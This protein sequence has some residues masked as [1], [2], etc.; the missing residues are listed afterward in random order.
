MVCGILYKIVIKMEQPQD[1][2]YWQERYKRYKK[3]IEKTYKVDF[4]GVKRDIKIIADNSIDM[5]FGTGA[6]G[7]TPA[8]SLVDYELAL[9]HNLPLIKIID[10]YGKMTSEAGKFAGLKTKDAS[11]K[12]VDYLKDKKLLEKEKDIDN[13]L[14]ICYRC[15]KAIEPIPSKQWFLKMTELAKPAIKAVKDGKIKFY[16]ARWKNVYL[17]WMENIHD[18]C[19]SRQI[20]W[21]HKL[22]VW[23]SELKTKNEKLKTYVGDNPPKG[24]KQIDDV[25]DTWFSSA[26]WPFAVLGW[27]QKTKDIEKF[28]P[29]STLS[30]ARDII[31]LWVARMIFSGIEFTGEIPFSEVYIH[32]TVFNKEGKRMSKSLGTGV[33]P[34][35]LIDKYGTDATRFGLVYQDTGVQDMKF[36][37]EAILAGKKFANKIWNASRY[38]AMNAASYDNSS[39]SIDN[40]PVP[41]TEQDHEI[42]DKLLETIKKYDKYVNNFQFGQAAHLIYDFFWHDFCDIY[43]E[44]SKMQL[45]N[46]TLKENTK[47]I[48]LYVLVQSLKLLHPLI[49][50]V[51]EEIYQNLPVK[52]KDKSIMISK[53]P[54]R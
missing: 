14:S 4:A 33:D 41:D 50:F 43:L 39:E 45:N 3:Y 51:T 23:Q 2:N 44:A 25:L 15:E 6:V 20:W 22:P 30:T 32:P 28:Y 29:T 34:L 8:H 42:L 27:P 46:V 47:N 24:Y 7:V 49:P 19:I 53:W 54:E 17:E 37:E 9:K 48:L 38:V 35:E 52:N 1:Y 26:L 31:Y 12:I 10:R 5:K 36:S 11:E 16:P 18:W 21:G 40:Y 13:N